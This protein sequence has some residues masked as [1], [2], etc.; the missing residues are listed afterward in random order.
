MVFFMPTAVSYINRWFAG[1]LRARGQALYMSLTFGAG[2]MLGMFGGGLA[3][4]AW[5]AGVTYSAASLCCLAG[6]ALIM[7]A[8]RERT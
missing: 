2:G 8:V 4:E 3:W 7:Q 6:F 5:G 1:A